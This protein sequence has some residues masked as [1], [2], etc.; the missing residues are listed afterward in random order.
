M[1]DE[2]QISPEVT[3]IGYFRHLSIRARWFLTVAVPYY[4]RKL[5]WLY[6]VMVVVWLGVAAFEFSLG[7][8]L[9]PII[10]LIVAATL[11][12]TKLILRPED[13]D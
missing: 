12:I 3:Q 2:S 13:N 1:T 11:V 8:I 9:A 4:Y 6:T 5:G 7:L 10:S